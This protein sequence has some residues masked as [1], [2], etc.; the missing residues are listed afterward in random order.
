MI[1]TPCY[2][3]D[4]DQLKTTVSRIQKAIPGIPLTFSIKA[5]SFV[6][7]SIIHEIA[8]VEVCSP[9]ELS[10]CKSRKIDPQKII[11]SGVM[12][13]ALDIREAISYG[14]GILTAE[15]KNQYQ[16]ISSIAEE[17]NIK[18]NVLLR[19]SSDNQFGM[20]PED[21]Y[22]IIRDREAHAN[23]V[24]KGFH[25]YSGTQKKKIEQIE[26][27]IDRITAVIERCERDYGY[28]PLL[29]EYGPGL[30][31]EYF[32]NNSDEIDLE[33]LNKTAPVIKE[34]A[35]KVPLGIEMGRFIAAACGTYY[36]S[37]KDLKTNFGINYAILDGGIHQIKYYGQIMAMHSP[38]IIQQPCRNGEKLKYCLC[39]SLC[40]V[41]D[42]LIKE[43]E[44]QEL[45][46]GDILEF[47]KC[48]AYSLTE[49]S[50]LFLSRDM[51]Y[52]YLKEE[53]KVNLVRDSR[54][55]S[56]INTI[57]CHLE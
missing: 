45:Q 29:V 13:E 42:V 6:I 31:V 18:T 43:A 56:E 20:D 32:K 28:R 55:S 3:Y 53:G 22:T 27:D 44:L 47:Q 25:Y 24:L 51:A 40:T 41:A 12:K 26:T 49:A 10:I 46:I 23:I 54:H 37:V 2:V 52:V 14:A 50:S 15:S 39:G 9:G 30:A 8:S 33:L 19:I 35:Q 38:I 4:I 21:I 16:L 11:Y 17:L 1:Q 48:G 34:F 5:N 57:D 36:T 7:S